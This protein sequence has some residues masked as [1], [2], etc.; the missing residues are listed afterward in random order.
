MR[1]KNLDYP[2]KFNMS[3]EEMCIN[4]LAAI[5]QGTWWLLNDQ[6]HLDFSVVYLYIFYKPVVYY[7]DWK[8]VI[9]HITCMSD[10]EISAL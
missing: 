10:L 1:I 4:M 6:G 2:N 7:W 3:N 8:P 9:V 5:I